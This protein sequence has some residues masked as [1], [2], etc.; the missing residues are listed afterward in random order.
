MVFNG[1]L[2]KYIGIMYLK[3]KEDALRNPMLAHALIQEDEEDEI[4][5]PMTKRHK[6]LRKCSAFCG[7][8]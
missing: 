7:S 1:K 3:E 5:V 2:R 4:G 8:I 6:T